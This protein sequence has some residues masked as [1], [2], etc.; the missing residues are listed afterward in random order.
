VGAEE[1]SHARHRGGDRVGLFPRF[2]ELRARRKVHNLTGD[3]AWMVDVVSKKNEKRR[4]AAADEIAT[5]TEDKITPVHR[6]AKRGQH[7]CLRVDS[8][9]AKLRGPVVEHRVE[10]LAVLTKTDRLLQHGG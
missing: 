7:R 4:R 2:H 3:F 6:L 9:V 5:D 8:S 1:G 10:G